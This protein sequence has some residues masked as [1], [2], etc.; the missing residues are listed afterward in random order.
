[1]APS[2][3]AILADFLLAPAPLRNFMS[4]SQFTDIFPVA[5]RSNP[6]IK[7]LYQELNRAR[8]ADIAHVRQSIKREVKASEQLK[9][10]ITRDRQHADRAAVAG[11]D[12]VALGMEAELSTHSQRGKPH[13]LPSICPLIREACDSVAVQVTDM[14]L[15]LQKVR[16]EVRDAIG[17]LS[18]L[19]YGH[20][21][22]SPGTDDEL[23]DELLATLKRLESACAESAV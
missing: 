9:R 5:Q 18:D 14:E 13:T 4:L 17:G 12:P 21:P 6:A 8:E 16:A 15:E 3:G 1:M 7:E 2:E 11:L 20:F 19:R 23:G 10:S 22:R